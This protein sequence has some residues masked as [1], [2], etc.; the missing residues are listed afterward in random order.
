M[1][2]KRA[3]LALM[4]LGFRPDDV[5]AMPEEAAAAWLKAAAPQETHKKLIVRKKK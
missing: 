1:P 2:I 5:M 3:T 4:R